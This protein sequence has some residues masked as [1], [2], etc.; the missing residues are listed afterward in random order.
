LQ[1]KESSLLDLV[2]F[3]KLVELYFDQPSESRENFLNEGLKQIFP[4]LSVD[5]DQTICPNL[6]AGLN[7]DLSNF[8]LVNGRIIALPDD[9]SFLQDDFAS[10]VNYEIK[11]IVNP[12]L[13]LLAS[14][15][16]DVL[17]ESERA[18]LLFAISAVSRHRAL[19]R[20]TVQLQDTLLDPNNVNIMSSRN[21]AS[22]I[23]VSD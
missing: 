5:K 17:Q 19:K 13:E 23:H 15:Q 22:P 1:E 8:I 3:L 11:E 10:L 9:A 21:D 14:N 20:K 7:T 4:N 6:I 2:K 12:I 16:V 18:E